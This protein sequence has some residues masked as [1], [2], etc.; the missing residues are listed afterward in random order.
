[1]SD[2]S[3]GYLGHPSIRLDADLRRRQISQL[4]HVITPTIA[5]CLVL[6]AGPEQIF[7]P[8]ATWTDWPW[9]LL[10]TMTFGIAVWDVRAALLRR[11]GREPLTFPVACAAQAWRFAEDVLGVNT[12]PSGSA[13]YVGPRRPPAGIWEYCSVGPLAALA[14]TASQAPHVKA[15]DWLVA[16]LTRLASLDSDAAWQEAAHVVATTTVP[17]LL[18]SA[19]F[20]TMDMEDRQRTSVAVAMRDAILCSDVAVER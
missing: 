4:L 20:R 11:R 16:T 19:F 12:G 7:A 18:H 3:Y 1:M 8:G 17:T 13:G 9:N 6:T 10:L 14:Y 2:M 15:A 5:L